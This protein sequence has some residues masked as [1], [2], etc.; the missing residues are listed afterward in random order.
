MT[1]S[2]IADRLRSLASLA[3]ARGLVIVCLAQVD[4]HFQAGAD[5]FPDPEHVRLPNPVDLSLFTKLCFVNGGKLRVTPGLPKARANSAGYVGSRL[6]AA[7]M[8]GERFVASFIGWAEAIF[9][10]IAAQSRCSCAISTSD[11][12]GSTA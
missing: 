5:A 3:S 7:W 2:A 8:S 6:S 4:R 9:T 1:P 10:E 11:V 12:G